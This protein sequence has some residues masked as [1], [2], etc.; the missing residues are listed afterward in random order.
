MSVSAATSQLP[1]GGGGVSAYE[2]PSDNF[3]VMCMLDLYIPAVC[4]VHVP[5]HRDTVCF[6]L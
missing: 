2:V 1:G 5:Y 6:G 3:R 4:S